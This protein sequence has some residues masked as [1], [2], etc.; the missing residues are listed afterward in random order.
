VG[1]EGVGGGVRRTSAQRDARYMLRMLSKRTIYTI[2][3]E[4][5]IGPLTREHNA[6]VRIKGLFSASWI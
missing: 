3:N 2:P 1:I 6:A 4:R 5:L